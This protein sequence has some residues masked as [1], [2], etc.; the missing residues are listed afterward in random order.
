M[1]NFFHIFFDWPWI[2]LDLLAKAAANATESV[3]NLPFRSVSKETL[4]CEN[5]EMKDYLK[6]MNSRFAEK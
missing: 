2:G 6:M 3:N 1:A 5:H 4:I